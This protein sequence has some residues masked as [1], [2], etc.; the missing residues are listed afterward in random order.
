MASAY[1]K[2]GKAYANKTD[3]FSRFISA[4]TGFVD[5][6]FNAKNITLCRNSLILFGSSLY[7]M[8]IGI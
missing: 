7:N 6:S 3:S 5:G 4:F 2:V 1:P 8:S